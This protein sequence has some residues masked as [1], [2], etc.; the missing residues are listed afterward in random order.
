VLLYQ[1]PVFAPGAVVGVD[2]MARNDD[3]THVIKTTRPREGEVHL[4][5]AFCHYDST[6]WRLKDRASTGVGF[7]S[8]TTRH[9]LAR[10]LPRRCPILVAGI[11]LAGW[12]GCF[13]MVT[14]VFG[15]ESRGMF[16][17]V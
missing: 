13:L 16:Q 2:R 14:K 17:Q 10:S 1:E 12:R 8:S 3:S 5:G 6:G 11:S 9:A 15:A 7:E 4:S